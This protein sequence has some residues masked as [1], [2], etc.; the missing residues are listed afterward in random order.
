MADRLLA[1]RK[2]QDLKV[3]LFTSCHRAEG[4][5]TLVLTL[6]ALCRAGPFA[7]CWSMLTSLARCW[8]GSWAFALT[9]GS[10]MW[11]RAAGH[12]RTP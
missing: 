11:S 9:S 2:R 8:L 5:T 1:A 4:R 7:P 3:I 12:L 10:T 6:A